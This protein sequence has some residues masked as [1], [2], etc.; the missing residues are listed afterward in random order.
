MIKLASDFTENLHERTIQ[1][2]VLSC[3]FVLV[4]Y[5]AVV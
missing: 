5:L 1:Q 3:F 4:Q 2:I